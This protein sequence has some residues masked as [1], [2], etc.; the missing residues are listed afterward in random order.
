MSVHFQ[1]ELDQLKQRILSLCALVEKNVAMA[2]RAGAT[3][4]NLE[5]VQFHPTALVGTSRVGSSRIDGREPMPLIT[6]STAA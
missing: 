2:A 5:M 6:A 1:N 3:L 4:A